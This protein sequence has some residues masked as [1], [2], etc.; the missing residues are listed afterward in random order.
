MS[1][2]TKNISIALKFKIVFLKSELTN[3]VFEM[4]FVFLLTKIKQHI[5]KYFLR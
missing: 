4:P 1:T 3:T 2:L 5:I